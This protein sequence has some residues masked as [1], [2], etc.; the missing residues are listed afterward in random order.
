MS[1]YARTL[2]GYLYCPDCA[3]YVGATEWWR[4]WRGESTCERCGWYAEVYQSTYRIA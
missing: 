1:V 4:D 2:D 3:T